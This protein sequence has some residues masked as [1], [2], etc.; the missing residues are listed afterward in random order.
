MVL[1]LW[2]M[3]KLLSFSVLGDITLAMSGRGFHGL[4]FDNLL[5]FSLNSICVQVPNREQISYLIGTPLALFMTGISIS[6]A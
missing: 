1:S 5:H 2:G 3:A 6:G 4:A